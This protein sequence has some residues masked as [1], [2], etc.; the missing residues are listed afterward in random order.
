MKTLLTVFLIF[1]VASY[2]TAQ[3]ELSGGMGIT[4]NNTP[5]LADYLN[6][7]YAP[8]DDQFSDF[9]SSILFFIEGAYE[10]SPGYD[11]AVE[12][13]YSLSSSTYETLS[14]KYELSYSVIKPSLLNYYVIRGVGYSFKF[15]GGVGIRILSADETLPITNTSYDYSSI[16]F[17]FVG[18]VEG[19][20]SLGGNLFANIGLEARYDLNGE[21]ENDGR[22]I[23]N[24]IQKDNVNFNSLS[25]GIRLG[26]LYQL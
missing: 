13:A 2:A 6:Q 8:D 12:V 5:S 17:G 3:V 16:G 26:L 15:G 9:S 24:A 20:T 10:V 18:K 14:G 1:I 4:F 19:N 7:N 25:F 11:W 23:Y 22:T 21:P